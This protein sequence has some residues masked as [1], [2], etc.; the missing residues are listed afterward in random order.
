MFNIQK[1]F[2]TVYNL[3]VHNLLYPL[4]YSNINNERDKIVVATILAGYVL[5][6][7]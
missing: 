4:I 5:L 6:T 2:K 1:D 3:S 7:L